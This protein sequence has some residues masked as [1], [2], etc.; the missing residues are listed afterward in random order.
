VA[1]RGLSVEALQAMV[2]ARG[3]DLYDEPL[4]TIAALESQAADAAGVA[5]AGAVLDAAAAS[6]C[7]PTLRHAGIA[8]E[9]AGLLHAFPWRAA[10]GQIVI[11]SEL[12]QGCGVEVEDIQ[13]GRAT[14]ALRAGLAELRA[15]AHRHFAAMAA[16]DPPHVL[17]PALLPVA[18]VPRWLDRLERAED[19]FQPVD[20][21]RWR[22]QWAMWRASRRPVGRWA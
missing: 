11:P 3:A 16:G 19:P 21:P 14:P 8:L 7:A 4:P 5:L 13:A 9:L 17:G 12:L 10:R 2:D 22:R 20:F 6:A 1:Q 15:L 18:L